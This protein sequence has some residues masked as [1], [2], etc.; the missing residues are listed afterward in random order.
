MTKRNRKEVQIGQF[1]V[2]GTS[3]LLTANKAIQKLF[4]NKRTGLQEARYKIDGKTIIIKP[5]G[6]TK[7]L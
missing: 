5:R 1:S 7:V 2:L 3:N 6:N 4:Q